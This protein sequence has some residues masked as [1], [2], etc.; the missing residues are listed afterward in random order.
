MVALTIS[1]AVGFALVIYLL[2]VIAYNQQT[3]FPK[4]WLPRGW[5]R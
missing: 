5:G 2:W 4:R 1:V 3:T